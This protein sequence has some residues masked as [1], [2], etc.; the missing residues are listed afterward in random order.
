ML[1]FEQLCQVFK[2][3]VLVLATSAPITDANR[4]DII[5]D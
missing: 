2:K 5:S 1:L 3:L 4:E